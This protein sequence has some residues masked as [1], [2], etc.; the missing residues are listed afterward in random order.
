MGPE[1][2]RIRSGLDAARHSLLVTPLVIRYSSLVTRY[3]SLA[4]PPETGC[5][6]GQTAALRSEVSLGLDRGTG[7][8]GSS[9]RPPI[10]RPGHQRRPQ[11]RR[12][13]LPETLAPRP[14]RRRAAELQ[15]RRLA[16]AAPFASQP[17]RVWTAARRPGRVVHRPSLDSGNP[18]PWLGLIHPTPRRLRQGLAV[19]CP[20]VQ[21]LHHARACAHAC[22]RAGRLTPLAEPRGP[23]CRLIPVWGRASPFDS[24]GARRLPARLGRPPS[25]SV[26]PARPSQTQPSGPDPAAPRIDAL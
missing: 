3:S 22:T 26:T 25:G 5:N 21:I 8:T 17:R 11:P 2:C 15:A 14:P 13:L 1:R 7:D 9:R 19:V 12:S 20:A 16:P 23:G 18:G 6:A 4:T 24:V 10:R